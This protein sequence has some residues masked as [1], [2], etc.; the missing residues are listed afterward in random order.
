MCVFSYFS[1]CVLNSL[2]LTNCSKSSIRMKMDFILWA[3]LMRHTKNKITVEVNKLLSTTSL[4]VLASRIRNIKRQ[5]VVKIVWKIAPTVWI[6]NGCPFATYPM[7]AKY[8]WTVWK[9]LIVAKGK[10]RA[11]K[12]V[13]YTDWDWLVSTFYIRLKCF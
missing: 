7:D 5:M 4:D 2:A 10:K 6:L 3:V 9:I 8:L 11:T 12:R 13:F 1:H